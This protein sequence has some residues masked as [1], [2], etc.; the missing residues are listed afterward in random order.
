MGNALGFDA[1]E[2]AAL[3]AQFS[4]D[5]GAARRVSSGRV[6][7]LMIRCGAYKVSCSGAWVMCHY[8]T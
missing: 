7:P 2:A 6:W 1:L 3:L 8:K 4:A 5:A